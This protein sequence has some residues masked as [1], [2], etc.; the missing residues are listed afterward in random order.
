MDIL[1]SPVPPV[2]S[3]IPLYFLLRVGDV[4]LSARIEGGSCTSGRLASD[5]VEISNV[6]AVICAPPIVRLAIGM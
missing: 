5:L 6:H 2:H 1:C 4:R 3:S